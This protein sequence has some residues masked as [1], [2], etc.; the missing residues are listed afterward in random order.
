M[1]PNKAQMETG[2]VRKGQKKFQR[3]FL[4]CQWFQE[5]M[6]IRLTD[7]RL[8]DA[9]RSDTRCV[10]CCQ[11]FCFSCNYFGC[12]HRG[13]RFDPTRAGG[14]AKEKSMAKDAKK[15]EF[16]PIGLPGVLLRVH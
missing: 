11:K 13:E 6:K 3:C 8:V 5:G 2:I 1:Q 15:T 9:M 12:A 10:E 16:E 14:L 7:N 4:C